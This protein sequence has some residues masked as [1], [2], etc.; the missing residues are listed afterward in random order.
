MSACRSAGALF[1]LVVITT[2]WPLPCGAAGWPAFRHDAA[3]SNIAEDVIAPPL[4]LQWTFVPLHQPQPAWPQEGKEKDRARFDEAFQVV[5]DGGA[6]FF[7]SSGD[8]KVYCLDA[9]T[10]EIRWSFI[11]GGP[12]RVAPTLANGRVYFGSD[13]GY[14][15]CVNAAEGSQV[16]R[17]RGSYASDEI[18]GNG[19]MISLWPVRTGVLVDK[20]TAYFGAGVFPHEGIFICAANADTGDII[21]RNDT[22]GEIGYKQEF[23]G[24]SP[25][26]PMLASD[27]TL[28]ITSGRAMPAAFRRDDGGFLYYLS[29]GGKVGGTWALLTGDRLIAGLDGK[30]V[31]DAEKGVAVHD[32]AYAW[33]PGQQLVVTQKLAY[34]ITPSELAAL[35]RQ[36]F[37]Q[38]AQWRGRIEEELKPVREQLDGLIDQFEEAPVAEQPALKQQIDV[39]RA[40]AKDLEDEIKRIE[41]AVHRWRRPCT[42]TDCLVLSGDTLYVGGNGAVAAASAQT[43]AD[44]WQSSIEGK[45]CGIAIAD[46]RMFVSADNGRIYCFAKDAGAAARVVDQKPAGPAAG[47]AQAAKVCADAAD[48]IVAA[49]K[50]KRGYG[51]VYGCGTGRLALELANRTDLQIIAVDSD[52]ANVAAARKLLD[53]AGLLGSR[54]LVE[55]VDLGALPYAD[56]FANL[57]VSE[58]FLGANWTIDSPE[59][60]V[61]V[62][63]PCGGV[64]CFGWPVGVDVPAAERNSDGI[65]AWLASRGKFNMKI[66]EKN[67]WWLVVER[68]P[69]EGA[70]K[71]THLY[72][73]P[74]NTACSD[75]QLVQGPLSTLWFGRPGPDLMVERHARANA[76]VAMDGRMF[77]QGENV[78]MAY[79]S[80]NGVLLWER[81]IPGALRVRVDSDM[82]NLALTENGLYV[83]TDGEC[84]RLDPA[85]GETLMT[86][87]APKRND[88]SPSRWGFLAAAGNT[89]FGSTGRPHQ[90]PYGAVWDQL[91]AEDGTWRPLEDTPLPKQPLYLDRVKTMMAEFPKPDTRAFWT[92]Q[93]GGYMW[94]TMFDFPA[95]GSVR[96]PVGAVTERIMDSDSFFAI[97]APTGKV[98]WAYR[99]KSIA[100]PTIAIGDGLVFL[101]DCDVTP[102]QKTAAIAER[103]ALVEK[104]VWEKEKQSYTEADADVRKVVA[105]DSETGEVKWQRVIDL[106]GCGGDRMGL[107]SSDGVL[108]F[109]GCFS[110][111]DRDLYKMG[112][113]SWR[114][115]TALNTKDG[116]DLWSKPLNYLRRPVIIGD[117]ILIEPRACELHTGNIITREHPFTGNDTTW[118]YVRP[119]H[120]CSI[121]SACPNMFFLRGYFLWYYD[122]KKDEGMMPYGAIRPGCWINVVP[123]NGLVLFPEASAGCTCSY[124]IRTTVA[125]KPKAKTERVFPFMVEHGEMTPVRH[126][127]I[128]FG[129]A[130]DRRDDAGTLWAAYPHPPNSAFQTY[131]LNF[132]L[133]ESFAGRPDY[134][135]RSVEGAG[136]ANTEI[137]WVFSSGCRG[138]AGFEVPLLKPEEGPGTYTVRL[139]FADT[140]N[141]GPG[142]RVFSIKIQDKKRLDDFD[143]IAEAGAPNTA[144]VKEFKGVKVETG[145]RL[146][147]VPRKGELS[148]NQWPVINGIEVVRED[149]VGKMAKLME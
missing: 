34:M 49:T 145:L 24:I 31:Y 21:W 25:Q 73:D 141:T 121:T 76:P 142:Q 84:L 71:W 5:S 45:A 119:G 125:L 15:Y 68:G 147:F 94:R 56:Y 129:A 64:G 106:T 63:K 113:L 3:R 66:D 51:L 95:W 61:R 140:E 30:R 144:V 83:A 43:G 74:G 93:Q 58:N 78:I 148:D 62:A 139:Y 107:A 47:D 110:N 120:C 126:M 57:I 91:V 8:S 36:S 86:Y 104:G 92:A 135:C 118:E 127:A 108:C 52:A 81:H 115:I 109:F 133:N 112:S 39:V 67:G 80:Y 136:I 28:F 60:L 128:N 116:A 75:D 26:G 101:A 114:R 99:G 6:V 23:G 54:V 105:L 38:A 53:D 46:G 134:F 50:I 7:G 132:A 16:W 137:P 44:L 122:L 9:A 90:F 11:A 2:V 79:D 97:D 89:V 100:H 17:A 4:A 143:I 42:L 10:G 131:G 12:V 55:Q 146:E 20:G 77:V 1:L 37:Q 124:P 70:G 111:H 87:A 59:E 82:G 48:A 13:D 103:A 65:E 33:F 85:T 14:A 98:R 123:A 41:D 29:P 27:S 72:A 35:D 88:G 18:I 149:T 102:E 19:K 32:T 22:T 138:I 69:L 117:T 40:Q 130:G 96:T